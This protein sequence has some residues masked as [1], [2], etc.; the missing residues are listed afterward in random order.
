MS[1][2]Y[3]SLDEAVDRIL[4]TST[5]Y[6]LS[7]L[8]EKP[9]QLAAFLVKQVLRKASL[10]LDDQLAIITKIRLIIQQCDS[11]ANL[12]ELMRATDLMGIMLHVLSVPS[13]NASFQNLSGDSR[14]REPA[15][16]AQQTQLEVWLIMCHLS[17]LDSEIM[18]ALIF[19]DN[20]RT[21]RQSNGARIL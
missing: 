13:T 10:E 3:R 14:I 21:N 16:I 15:K 18:N 1:D 20:Y 11:P 7:Q 8:R 12:I 6:R 9:L 17:A 2:E 19:E 4:Q 5:Q